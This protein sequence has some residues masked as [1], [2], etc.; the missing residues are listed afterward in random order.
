MRDE[1]IYFEPG[2]VLFFVFNWNWFMQ[3]QLHLKKLAQV[4]K[5]WIKIYFKQPTATLGYLF[6]LADC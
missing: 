4:H 6:S 2:V 1:I 5:W 3:C